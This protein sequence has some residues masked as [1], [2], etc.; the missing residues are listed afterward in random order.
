VEEI[1]LRHIDGM[2]YTGQAGEHLVCYL[3]HMWKYNVFQPLNPR[4]KWDFVVERD[5]DF[6]TIQVKTIGTDRE[7]TTLSHGTKYLGTKPKHVSEGEYDYLCVCK[8][9]VVYVI[10][11]SKLSSFS[12]VSLRKYPEYAWDLND[13]E[14]Y[15]IRHL[16]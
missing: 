7:Y 11:F 8:F 15:K 5:G 6:K 2:H 12:T 13:P 1:G 4:T 10:P 3:F 16:I 9:P 14:T